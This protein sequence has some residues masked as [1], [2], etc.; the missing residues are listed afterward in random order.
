MRKPLG[1]IGGGNMGEALIAGVLQSG[2]LSPEEIQFYEPRMERRDY[3]RDKYRV[4]SA[5]SNG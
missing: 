4:P 5:K 1:I 2:L 3:L